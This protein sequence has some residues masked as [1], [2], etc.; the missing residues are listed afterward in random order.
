M[1]T[2]LK[3]LE[4]KLDTFVNN[5]FRRGSSVTLEE[6][7][8]WRGSPLESKR[9]KEGV[10]PLSLFNISS[11][12][13]N[14]PANYTNICLPKLIELYIKMV[15]FIVYKSYINKTGLKKKKVHK[16]KKPAP[17]N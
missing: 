12:C 8:I 16:N 6:L 13:S 17:A 2:Y 3:I 11:I 14:R 7:I 10:N 9:E 15:N 5:I 4:M 1:F